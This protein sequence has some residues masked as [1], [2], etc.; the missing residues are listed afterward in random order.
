VLAAQEQHD[1]SS[2]D[3]YEAAA[4]DND[5]EG[6]EAVQG[7]EYDTIFGDGRDFMDID[8]PDDS[9]LVSARERVLLKKVCKVAVLRQLQHVLCRVVSVPFSLRKRLN[10]LQQN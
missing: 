2:G 5:A 7:D 3:G 4:G 8:L 10:F 6:F 1:S 9:A